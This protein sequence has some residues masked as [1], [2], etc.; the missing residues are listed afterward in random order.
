MPSRNHVMEGSVIGRSGLRL[1]PHEGKAAGTIIGGALQL[2][3]SPSSF[4][5][6]CILMGARPWRSSP[7]VF[8]HVGRPPSLFP[9][10]LCK[11]FHSVVEGMVSDMNFGKPHQLT[12][13]T[14]DF[15]PTFLSLARMPLKEQFCLHV[16]IL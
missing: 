10:C 4:A 3:A 6:L 8:L 16:H 7:I 9:L 2:T 1:E 11:A 14:G 15:I 13:W 5:C 12:Y